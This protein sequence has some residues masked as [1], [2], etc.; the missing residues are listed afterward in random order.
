MSIQYGIDHAGP[1]FDWKRSCDMPLRPELRKKLDILSE[2]GYTQGMR[3]YTAEK[4]VM[5]N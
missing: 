3:Q 4:G 2:E 1:F 5:G